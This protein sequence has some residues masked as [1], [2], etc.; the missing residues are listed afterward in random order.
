M[1]KSEIQDKADESDRSEREKNIGNLMLE[2]SQISDRLSKTLDE[3]NELSGKNEK[4]LMS[5]KQ[6]QKEKDELEGKFRH[7]F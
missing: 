6:L 5:L 7:I 2:K 4:L 1:N 3:Y